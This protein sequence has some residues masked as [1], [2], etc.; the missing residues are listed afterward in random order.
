MISSPPIKPPEQ[1]PLDITPEFRAA[2]D[3]L[4]NGTGNLFITGRAGTGKSTL[5]QHFRATTS[6]NM[7]VLAPTGV[8]AVNVGGQTIHSFFGFKPNIT[9]EGVKKK[10]GEL[11]KLY[12]KLDAV[13]IDEISMVRADLFDALARFLELNGRKPGLPFGGVHMIFFGDLYQLSPVVRRAEEDLFRDYYESPYFFSAKSFAGLSLQWI[14]LT[15][16]FRQTDSEFLDL[17]NRIRNQTITDM[18]L[19]QIN[20][21]MINTK[22]WNDRD[23]TITLTTTKRQAE[24]VNLF[25]LDRLHGKKELFRACVEGDFEASSYP[26][27]VALTLKAGAQVM[28]LNNDSLGRWVNGTIARIK[29]IDAKEERLIVTL[30]DQREEEILPFKWDMFHFTMDAKSE[31]LVPVSV[32]TFTQIPV[33]LAWAITIHKSQ[34]LT[35]DRAVIDLTH[36]TFAHGQLYVAISRLRTLEGLLLTHPVRKSDIFLDRRI[37]KFITTFQYV[38]SENRLSLEKK[39]AF[40]KE[41]IR[42]GFAIEMVYLKA[43][44][45]K[46]TRRILPIRVGEM[47]FA[48]KPFPG[49]IAYCDNRKEERTFNVTRI[50]EMRQIGRF[51]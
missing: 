47:V 4:E 51:F 12:Q 37:Q 16:V 46:T 44:D 23:D 18:E 40:L 22:N 42:D 9:L 6:K 25:Q 28:L 17:L 7:V 21:R 11:L 30:P 3:L 45:E 32:G 33:R 48:D 15:K 2:L 26:T 36:R 41:A 8:A 38:Q 29:T 39:M 14:E 13:V 27:E 24:A 1:V 34:G 5:L 19:T 20:R 43:S 50:L 49:I 31:R 10:R 35:F